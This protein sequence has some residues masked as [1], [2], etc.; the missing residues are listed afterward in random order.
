MWKMT[1]F[2]IGLIINVLLMTDSIADREHFYIFDIVTSLI[3]W[4]VW[5]QS[6][7]DSPAT[8]CAFWLWSENMI[9]SIFLTL[10]QRLTRHRKTQANPPDVQMPIDA[11]PA[12]YTRAH[13]KCSSLIPLINLPIAYSP[14]LPL[15]TSPIPSCSLPLPPALPL[16][17]SILIYIS[18]P[19]YLS[20]FPSLFH[21]PCSISPSPPS[22]SISPSLS[23]SLPLCLLS[24]PPPLS[25]CIY[26]PLFASFISLSCSSYTVYIMI[27]FRCSKLSASICVMLMPFQN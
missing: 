22:L 18:L 24:T 10:S 13:G 2:L 26:L 7:Y 14:S 4:T 5:Y 8:L 11:F 23:P 6:T 25:P 9:S 27:P 15:S 3:L 20:L 19:L 17:P 21:A 12:L 1:D 16:S